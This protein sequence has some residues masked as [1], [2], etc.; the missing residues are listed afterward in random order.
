MALPLLVLLLLP[1]IVPARRLGLTGCSGLSSYS[2][3]AVPHEHPG[4]VGI[5]ERLVSDQVPLTFALRYDKGP[6]L[7]PPLFLP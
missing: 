2:S 6:F 7:H 3:L 4:H 5:R 1:T